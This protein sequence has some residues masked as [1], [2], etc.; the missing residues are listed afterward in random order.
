MHENGVSLFM[1]TSRHLQEGRRV[2]RK[3]LFNGCRTLANVIGLSCIGT[4]IERR[5]IESGYSQLAR[6]LSGAIGRL[7]RL[8][9]A[10]SLKSL[11]A[12]C[13]CAP[14]RRT[15]DPSDFRRPSFPVCKPEACREVYASHLGPVV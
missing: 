3:L 9:S 13:P 6:R 14:K 11:A 8:A 1:L 2:I 5:C 12:T 7:S 15:I 10:A 4:T